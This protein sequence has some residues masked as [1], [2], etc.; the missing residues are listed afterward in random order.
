MLFQQGNQAFFFDVYIDKTD[1][2]NRC[3]LIDRICHNA[4]NFFIK[5]YK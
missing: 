5:V 3:I 4:C 2:K 1:R